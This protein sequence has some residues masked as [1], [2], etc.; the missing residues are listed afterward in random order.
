MGY[1]QIPAIHPEYI[2]ISHNAR[3]SNILDFSVDVKCA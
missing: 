1:I 2:A 3:R